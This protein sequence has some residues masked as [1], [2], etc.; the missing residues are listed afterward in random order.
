MCHLE[1][2]G[3]VEMQKCCG[4]PSETTLSVFNQPGR[5]SGKSVDHFL[6]DR[7]LAAATL[8]VLLNCDEVR[9]YLE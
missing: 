7:E 1:A 5:A 6:T 9:P 3:L 8:Y 4:E 2:I